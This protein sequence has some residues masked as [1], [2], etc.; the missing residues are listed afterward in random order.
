MINYNWDSEFENNSKHELNTG[1]RLQQV[2]FNA[3]R[4]CVEADEPR[5]LLELLGSHKNAKIYALMV[6]FTNWPAVRCIEELVAD[7]TPICDTFETNPFH[8]TPQQFL[9][10][11]DVFTTKSREQINAAILRGQKRYQSKS[12]AIPIKKSMRNILNPLNIFK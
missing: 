3:I 12:H 2:S 4:S 7:G 5:I 9:D 6:C 8:M 10:K 1:F 11:F